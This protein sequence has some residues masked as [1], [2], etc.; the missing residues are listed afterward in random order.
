M[1]D[2]TDFNSIRIHCES[3]SNL[4]HRV[5]DDIKTFLKALRILTA[6]ANNIGMINQV[7]LIP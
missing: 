7:R 4:T 2:K 6:I 1:S 3:N 5:I